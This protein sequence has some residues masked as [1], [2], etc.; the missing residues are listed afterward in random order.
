MQPQDS[1]KRRRIIVDSDTVSEEI[2]QSYVGTQFDLPKLQKI[3]N[4]ESE[5]SPKSNYQKSVENISL[6][7]KNVNLNE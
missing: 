4:R 1:R 5:Q 6:R 2:L 7:L 3:I